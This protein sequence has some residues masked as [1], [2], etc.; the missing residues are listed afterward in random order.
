MAVQTPDEERQWAAEKRDFVADRRDELAAVRDAPVTP[1]TRRP[2]AGVSRAGAR[3]AAGCPCSGAR[4]ATGRAD[5]SAR[6]VELARLGTMRGRTREDL[7]A[8]A[9]PRLST[10]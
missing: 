3:A 8:G 10:G 6:R 4:A 9:T 5:T 7:G 1:G 2:R